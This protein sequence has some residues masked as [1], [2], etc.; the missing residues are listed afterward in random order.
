MSN[1]STSRRFDIVD[2]FAE[3]RYQGNQLA[4]MQSAGDLSDEE[5][6]RIALETNFSETTFLRG[7]NI[8]DGFDVRIFTPAFEIPFAGHPTLGTAAVIRMLTDP[9]SDRVTLNLQVG[10]V[11][12]QFED[13]LAW[14]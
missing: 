10:A 3:N 1:S 11:P 12:V 14:L 7:G 9:S 4:V 8:T 6:Q 5:M 2:V 13:E